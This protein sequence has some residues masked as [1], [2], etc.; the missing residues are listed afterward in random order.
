MSE[1]AARDRLRK[2]GW[3]APGAAHDHLMNA[4]KIALP[5]LIGVLMAYLAMAPLARTQDISF[6]LDKNK[7]ALAKERM[8]VQS[9]EYRGEDSKGRAFRIAAQSAVQATSRDPIVDIRGMSAEIALD[10]GPAALRADRGRYNIET[11]KVGVIGPI[12]FTAPDGYRLTTHDV[13]ADLSRRTMQSRGRV[14]GTMP[15]GQFSADHL[16]ADLASRVVTL[17]GNARLHIVQ[18]A[19]R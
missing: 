18:G 19:I 5:A 8:R 4:L 6:I 1:I 10:D 12:L 2:Q 3:A 13:V 17:T 7:V 11:E 14:D 15:L 9:A 16:D